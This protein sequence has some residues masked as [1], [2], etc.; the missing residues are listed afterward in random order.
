MMSPGIR[1]DEHAS[2]STTARLV[3]APAAAASSLRS[4]QR[5]LT[6]TLHLKH[7]MFRIAT[8]LR[9]VDQNDVAAENAESATMQHPYTM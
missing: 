1:V 2:T 3:S 7:A 8:R 6:R 9:H 5:C 4:T